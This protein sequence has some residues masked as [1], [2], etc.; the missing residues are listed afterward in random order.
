MKSSTNTSMISTDFYRMVEFREF[1]TIKFSNLC[2]GS[3]VFTFTKLEMRSLAV[4]DTSQKNGGDSH[5]T[6]FNAVGTTSPV[7]PRETRQPLLA[8][9]T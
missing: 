1:G 2:Q 6:I 9:R 3:V 5:H 7:L 8:G 4:S